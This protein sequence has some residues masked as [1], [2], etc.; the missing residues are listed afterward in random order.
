M[1][2]RYYKRVGPSVTEVLYAGITKD[3]SVAFEATMAMQRSDDYVRTA[4]NM[5]YTALEDIDI[6]SL[7][8]LALFQLGADVYNERAVTK[9]MCGDIPDVFNGTLG[10]DIYTTDEIDTPQD[11]T[12]VPPQPKNNNNILK[13]VD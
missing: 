6:T 11:A 7:Q 2:V 10:S 3:S 13:Y 4:Y 8:R 12:Y 9:L 1:G 5:K